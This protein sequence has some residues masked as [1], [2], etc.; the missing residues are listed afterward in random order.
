MN[1]PDAALGAVAVCLQ[2]DETYLIALND[3][4]GW[5]PLAHVLPGC[6]H[7]T[8]IQA[9]DKTWYLHQPNQIVGNLDVVATELATQIAN[10]LASFDAAMTSAIRRTLPHAALNVRWN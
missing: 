3:L 2:S 5:Y 9:G 7:Y 8:C 1:L 6:I 4:D 10:S